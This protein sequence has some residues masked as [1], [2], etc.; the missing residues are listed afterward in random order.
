MQLTINEITTE[1][2]FFA[3]REEWKELFLRCPSATPFQSPEWL[4]SWWKFFGG[5]TLKAVEIR[6]NAK[7]AGVAPLFIYNAECDCRRLCFIGS[8][9]SDYLDCLF[10]E[11]Y[12]EA[13]VKTVMEYL[14]RIAGEW[15]ECDFQELR[16]GSPFLQVSI[17]SRFKTAIEPMS[18]CPYLEKRTDDETM[19]SIIPKKLRKNVEH[20]LRELQ[21]TGGCTFRIADRTSLQESLDHL[22]RLHELRWTGRNEPGVLPSG[23]LREFHNE[24]AV[25]LLDAG[26]LN[27]YTLRH[28][29]KVIAVY[30]VLV[31][32][33]RAFFY[34]AGF[35]PEMEQYS[36]GTTA[37]YCAVEDTMKKGI[38]QF[39]FMRGAETYKY[40]WGARDSMNFRLKLNKR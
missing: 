13:C 39:D 28:D 14:G 15:D 40:L 24:T 19:R 5:S 7:L 10:G 27:L 9:I 25:Q 30:Y 29:E 17:P 4:M 11:P 18:V 34:L 26:L 20:A 2:E 3:A 16:A 32:G 31:H 37:L 38:T 23:K 12:R 1:K 6:D 8:G 22:Y 33:K 36:P 35:D 21:K